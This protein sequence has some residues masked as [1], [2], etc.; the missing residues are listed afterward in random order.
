MSTPAPTPAEIRQAVQENEHAPNGLLRNARAE[1]LVAAAE[2][3]GDRSVLRTALFGLIKAYEY[4]T[5]RGKMLVP[6]A[7]LM[8]EWD[9]DPSAFDS[10][11][12]YYFHWM[13]KW[14]TSGMLSLPEVPLSAMEGWLVEMERRYRLAGF[15][16]RAVRQAEFD[17]ADETGDQERADRAF[18]AWTAADRDRMANCHACELNDQGHHWYAHGDDEKA[19]TVWEPVLSGRLSCQEEPHRT[20]AKSLIP[21]VRLG[22]T[23]EARAHHL[24]GYRMARGNESLLPTIG[25]HI[26]FCALTG[27]EGRGL[28]ILSEHAS[29]LAADGNPAAQLQ[30]YTGVL[31]LLGRLA[32]LG[33]GEQPVAAYEGRL[34]TAA[35]LHGLLEAEAAR[36]AVSF[37]ERNGST[38]VSGRLADRVGS[39]PLL[40]ALP[41]GVRPSPAVAVPAPTAAVRK[42]AAAAAITDVA[43]LA[44]EARRLRT[45]GHPGTRAVWNRIEALIRDGAESVDSLL[46]AE[47]LEH[48]AVRT[49]SREGFEAAVAAYRAAGEPSRAAI[50]EVWV[51]VITAQQGADAEEVRALLATAAASADALDPADPT[52]VRRIAAV[53]L[54]RIRLHTILSGERETDLGPAVEEFVA[55]YAS[56]PGDVDDLLADAETMLAQRAWGA[57]DWA[58]AEALLTSA[59]ERGLGAG[60]PWDAVE[61]LGRRASLQLMLG[62]AGDAEESARAALEHSAELTDPAELGAV[63]LSLAEVLYRQDGKEAEAAEHAL[64]AAHWFDAAG[65]TAGAGAM[66]RLVLAQAY[67][68]TGRA[69]EAAEV[70]ESALPDLLEHGEEEA[71]RA[72][73]ILGNQLRELRD[74]RAAAEQ[75]LL[76]AEIAKG[77]EHPVPQA[78]LATMAAECLA[79]AGLAD[80]AEQAYVR[81][82]ELWGGAGE[83]VQLARAM[84]SLAWLKVRGDEP[85]EAAVEVARGLMDQA[86]DA[87]AGDEPEL[88]VEQARTWSQLAELITDGLYND[89]DEVEEGEDEEGEADG[90]AVRREAVLLWQRAAEVFGGLGPVFLRDRAQCVTRLAWTERELG[91][92]A[93]GA[94][95]LR[96]LVEELKASDTEGAGELLP[97]LEQQLKHLS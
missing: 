7:R 67:G 24:R 34:R 89:D 60:R 39:A 59:A 47:L 32:E 41:L 16:E 63:R 66:A 54:T 65:D 69:A 18:A 19:L 43:G 15:T 53:D 21:L 2:Q 36:I 86:L 48:A 33:Q 6:F 72:R 84:R 76:A 17:L 8:R 52:R 51:T 38:V 79:G 1:E 5:E 56:H 28:E 40:G 11:D 46:A 10:M 9:Q 85:D 27:N 35:E 49:P 75:Y 73:E 64:D 77:W 88:L 50:N 23:D 3:T 25:L 81:A 12:T 83:A 92:G 37:D 91:R 4:S 71:V 74:L 94:R 30:L 13:F 78:R 26:E 31:V 55:R 96:E 62:R 20:L 44:A 45:A 82:L 22:R 95:S 93:E 58:P 57:H 61:P 87:V 42:E 97:Q 14:V 70:L 80:E 68:E 29:H 90:A